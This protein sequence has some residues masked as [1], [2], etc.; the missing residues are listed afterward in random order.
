MPCLARTHNRVRIIGVADGIGDQTP[1]P[2]VGGGNPYPVTS[3]RYSLDN[4]P[5]CPPWH[6]PLVEPPNS[7]LL[8]SPASVLPMAW[9]LI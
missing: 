7:H 9:L 8:V 4:I 2:E 6:G 3:T 5:K 1:F